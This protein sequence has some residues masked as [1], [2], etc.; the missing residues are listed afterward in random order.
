MAVQRITELR[1]T[2]VGTLS[3]TLAVFEWTSDTRSSMVGEFTHELAVKTVR[4][5]VPGSETPVEQ[6]LAATWQP[7]EF[8]GEWSDRWAGKGFALATYREF[9]RLVGRAPLV[10]LQL[11]EL[12]FVGLLTSLTITYQ[13]RD[14]IGW[15]VRM[16]PHTN[17]LVG[18]YRE[19]GAIP[20]V[21]RPA[22]QWVVDLEGN[23]ETLA[24]YQAGA[25]D[26]PARTDAIV[27]NTDALDRLNAALDEARTKVDAGLGA[28]TERTLFAV[29]STFRRVR[30]A[31][32][33]LAQR[34]G[35][36]R[37]ELTVAFDD[38]I[39]TLK[40]VEWTHNTVA[41]AY[42]AVG[43]ASLAELDM[44]ATA[45]RKP[46]SIHRCTAGE[47]LERIALRYYGTA[48]HWRAIYDANNLDSLL[49][50]DGAELIIPERA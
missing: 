3:P 12:A 50:E 45:A 8:E 16:S 42:R 14:R 31:G 30:S 15:R 27:D 35:S 36:K 7:F 43:L 39:Q 4:E 29:A 34:V 19:R 44:R 48:N 46:R 24:Y 49:L 32:L 10:R 20:R 47:S 37:A 6:V 17:E 21:A 18:T 5:E 38:A 23:A 11:D 2:G 26:I 41:E 9:A 13:T 25:A 28:D 1:R 33:D 22:M 40:F